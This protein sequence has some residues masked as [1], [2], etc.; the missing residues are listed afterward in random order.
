VRIGLPEDRGQQV[1][2]VDLVVAGRL[3]VRRRALEDALEAERLLRRA[4]VAIGERLL[5][6]EV[7]LQLLQ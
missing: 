2:A 1:G 3:H 7:R 5:L 6:V 4:L